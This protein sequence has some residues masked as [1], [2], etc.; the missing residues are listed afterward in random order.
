MDPKKRGAPL[1]TVTD[2]LSVLQPQE[3]LALLV[4]AEIPALSANG[5]CDIPGLETPDPLLQP[6]VARDA[7]F[8]KLPWGSMTN[9]RAMPLSKSA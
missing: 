4:E 1:A 3:S 5:R 2:L 7:V 9:F 8:F 6:F